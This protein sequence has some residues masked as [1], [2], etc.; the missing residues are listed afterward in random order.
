M[1][2]LP[3]TEKMK[4]EK[5][6]TFNVTSTLTWLKPAFAATLKELFAFNFCISSIG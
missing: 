4:H 1:F 3:A 6:L 2:K 5:R